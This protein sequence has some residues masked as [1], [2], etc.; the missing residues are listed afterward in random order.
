[1]TSSS[2]IQDKLSLSLDE[3]I[4]SSKPSK[5]NSSSQRRSFPTTAASATPFRGRGNPM[6]RPMRGPSAI[7]KAEKTNLIRQKLRNRALS[8]AAPGNAPAAAT[9]FSISN[10]GQ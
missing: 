3:I 9:G 5:V 7:A 2:S 8:A 6:L 10:R 1:M 4:K